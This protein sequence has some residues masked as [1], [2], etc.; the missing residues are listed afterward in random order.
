MSG[1][2]DLASRLE[3]PV[4][5]LVV[6][7][8]CSAL[9]VCDAVEAAVA[10][11]VDWVQIRERALESGALLE[12]AREVCAAAQRGATEHP[13]RI[14]VNRRVDIALAIEADG[15]HL[16]FDAMSIADARALLPEAAWIG[17]SAH[18]PEEV[19]AAAVA[20]ADYAHLAPILMPLS[21]SA[22]RQALG[23]E[24]LAEAASHGLGVLAQGGIEAP[25]CREVIA[26]GARG[27]AVTG[28]ILM[29]RDPA[30]VAAAMREALD[31]SAQIAKQG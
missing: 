1:D 10:G 16:G 23:F 7:R 11:G 4:L 25:H 29:S 6:D 26:S 17:C 21:K 30:A 8:V 31:A 2:R 15:V 28:S 22:T 12:F 19:K 5:C 3:R 27:V 13:V 24:A 9:P 18:S 20:G 14:I